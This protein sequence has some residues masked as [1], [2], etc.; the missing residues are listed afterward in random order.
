MSL[1]ISTHRKSSQ[2]ITIFLRI[3]YLF[4][5]TSMNIHMFLSKTQLQKKKF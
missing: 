1:H 5:E 3:N 2:I 4:I